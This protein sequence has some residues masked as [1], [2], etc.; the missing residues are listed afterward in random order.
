MSPGGIARR[1]F[2][3]AA[4]GMDVLQG[5]DRQEPAPRLS[6]GRKAGRSLRR[7]PASRESLTFSSLVALFK[8]LVSVG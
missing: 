5:D 4:V 3:H 7:S 6:R 2:L 1:W 8:L